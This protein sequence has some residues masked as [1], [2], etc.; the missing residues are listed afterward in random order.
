LLY[1]L[2]EPSVLK[3]IIPVSAI[4]IVSRA[5]PFV[6]FIYYLL[7]LLFAIIILAGFEN[8][9]SNKLLRNL[10]LLLLLFGLWASVTSFWSDYPWITFSRSLYFIFI[11]AGAV[12]A[13]YLWQQIYPGSL[14]F[15]LPANLFIILLSLLSLL[16]N[17]PSESWTGGNAKGFMGFAAHQNTL[18]SVLLFTLPAVC[19]EI[20]SL[21]GNKRGGLILLLFLNLLLILLTY[22]RASIL[23]LL[24]GVVVFLILTKKWKLLLYSSGAAVIIILLIFMSTSI[25]EKADELVRKDF[26]AFYSSR[27]WMW[28]PSYEAALTGGVTGLGYGMSHPDIILEGIGIYK[29]GRYIREKGNSFLALIEEVGVIGFILFLLPIGYVVKQQTSNVKRITNSK[30]SLLNTHY[31]LLLSA[32]LAFIIHAQFE[33]WMVGV[34]SVQLPLFFMFAGCVVN[35]NVK[36]KNIV[37]RSFWAK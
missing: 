7:P 13:G 23:A 3:I 5:F 33:A 25:K 12:V 28:V 14:S 26:P 24:C 19:A 37:H 32:F 29:E 15:L 11:S 18:A 36:Q 22:S 30:F 34:G 17:I 10:I 6:S 35:K 1:K 21:E 9:L 20:P 27:E 2:K 4:V 16:A 8:F 31:S